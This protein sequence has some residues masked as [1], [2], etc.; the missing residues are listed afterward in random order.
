MIS[1]T[2]GRWRAVAV[3]ALALAVLAGC[4]TDNLGAYTQAIDNRNPQQAAPDI[5]SEFRL[6]NLQPNQRPAPNSDEESLWFIVDRAES[7]MKT[8]GNRVDDARLTKYIESVTCRVAGAHCKDI[9]SYVLRIPAFNATMYPNGMTTVWT[10]LLLRVRNEAQL[11]AVIGHETGHFLRRHSIQR[12][13]NIIQ[14]SNAFMF[15][16]F[17]LAGAGAGSMNS[18][19]ALLVNGDIAAF[20]RDNEREADGYGIVLAAEAGYD[21]RE[22]AK[23]WQQLE[24]EKKAN[25]DQIGPV[26]FF[27]SHPPTEER[28]QMLALLGDKFASPSARDVGR[29]RF[30]AAI[31]P[32]RAGLLR[33]ELHLRKYDSF[34][35]LLD[36]LMEDGAN[37]AE[38]HY[39]K[40][41]MHRLRQ[42]EGDAKI[43]LNSYN[44]AKTIEGTA[45]ADIDRSMALVHRQ[46]R[47]DAKARAALRRYLD[48]NPKASDAAIVRQMLGDR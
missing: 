33:D 41:E 48:A 38:L 22:A 18:V 44:T 42:K 26:P 35:V 34:S 30:L 14:Q 8:A 27:A 45:P 31:L 12:M 43:A 40:G 10:G 6:S 21:P 9:R 19:L 23:I 16:Q 17:V 4:R 25:D 29:E 32:V 47:E 15:V 39:F 1:G 20:S 5:G 11:A 36:M 46:L 13:R 7:K 28:A 2:P 3:S 24:R 37:L